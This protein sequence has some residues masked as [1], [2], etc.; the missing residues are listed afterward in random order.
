MTHFYP[1]QV[2]WGILV[3]HL[4]QSNGIP[5][6]HILSS[7]PYPGHNSYRDLFFE[8]QLSALDTI[9]D[10]TI[11][12]SQYP[13]SVAYSLSLGLRLKVNTKCKC[14]CTPSLVLL[15]TRQRK[16][17]PKANAEFTGCY[18]EVSAKPQA[19][20]MKTSETQWLQPYTGLPFH[21][22]SFKI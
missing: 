3:L 2:T 22:L 21:V 13:G 5:F 8:A 10:F 6:S 17:L 11:L 4:S 15:I 16:S 14:Y 9:L 7:L 12:T 20:L 19:P 18:P 1:S